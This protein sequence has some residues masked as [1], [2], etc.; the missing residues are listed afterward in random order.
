V[1]LPFHDD[2]TG[3]GQRL[4]Y[5]LPGLPEGSRA[6][7]SY[8]HQRR[9]PNIPEPFRI[10]SIGFDRSQFPRDRVRRFYPRL[11]HGQR[12]H[13]LHRFGWQPGYLAHRGRHDP[14]PVLRRKQRI[15]AL[16]DLV[17][18]DLLAGYLYPRVVEHQHSDVAGDQRGLQRQQR[19][20]GVAHQDHRLSGGVRHRGH[21]LELPFYRVTV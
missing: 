16:D 17:R 14:V 18:V 2:E 11:P 6:V 15:E 20:V 8:Q 9:H 19:P 13:V 4:L 21:V 5:G 7:A 10:E 3:V 1:P 12:P